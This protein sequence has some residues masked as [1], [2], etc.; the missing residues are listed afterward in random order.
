MLIYE[1]INNPNKFPN[2]EWDYVMDSL[3]VSWAKQYLGHIFSGR[4]VK[5]FCNVLREI[6]MKKTKNILTRYKRVVKDSGVNIIN[7]PEWF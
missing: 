4:D 1:V 3:N 2:V 6:L 7:A 5:S